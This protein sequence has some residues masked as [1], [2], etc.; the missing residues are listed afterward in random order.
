M[1]GWNFDRW[2]SLGVELDNAVM[3]GFSDVTFGFH[4]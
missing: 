4:I 1:L 2:L 3:Q